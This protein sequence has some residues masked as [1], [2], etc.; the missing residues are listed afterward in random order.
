MGKADS[1][2][3]PTWDCHGC[4]QRQALIDRQQAVIEELGKALKCAIGERPADEYPIP[5]CLV[6]C[7]NCEHALNCMDELEATDGKNG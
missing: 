3:Y 7:A 6:H 4:E 1:R 5:D 2:T